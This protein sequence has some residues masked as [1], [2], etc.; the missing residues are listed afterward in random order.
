MDDSLQKFVGLYGAI[1]ENNLLK[2]E[3]LFES[4]KK[5]TEP[6]VLLRQNISK[7]NKALKEQLSSH[8]YKFVCVSSVRQ[9]GSSRYGVGIEKG[10]IR[11]I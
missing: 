5:Q 7:I 2:K 3:E 9:Y 8:D 1:Y 10:R 11:L 4:W 6:S